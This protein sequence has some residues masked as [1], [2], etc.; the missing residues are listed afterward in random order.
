MNAGVEKLQ[1]F[2]HFATIVNLARKMGQPYNYIAT[3]PADEVYMTLLFDKEV[4][5]Y[6]KRYSEI[7]KAVNTAK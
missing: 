2:G 5:E 4:N 6:E 3:L 7:M 1:V